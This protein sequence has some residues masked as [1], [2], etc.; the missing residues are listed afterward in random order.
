ML[1]SLRGEGLTGRYGKG[2]VLFRGVE[3]G[4]LLL[5]RLDFVR[6]IYLGIINKLDM[7]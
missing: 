6:R 7:N 1:F 3:G 4:G 5:L 2:G